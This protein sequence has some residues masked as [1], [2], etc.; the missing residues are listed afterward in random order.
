[1]S[2]RQYIP[3]LCAGGTVVIPK[4]SIEFE[5]AIMNAKVS[6]LICTPSALAALD[7]DNAT[8]SV[9]YVQVAGEAPRLS[10]LLEWNNCIDKLFVGLGP[11]ELC[12][13]ALC[14]E[15]DGKTLCIGFPANNVKAYVVD[16]KSALQ[17]PINVPGELWIA[18]K[19]VCK[20][21]LNREELTSSKF[22]LDPFV[23]KGAERL[24]R[25]GDLAKV[26]SNM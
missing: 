11:T 6:K 23:S 24:Y 21:Y 17:C 12:A 16:D 19:N 1:M 25:T 26:S 9:R 13:H 10:T 7:I 3:T 20:G 15:F 2:L 14:G 4:S 18:G 5:S 22:C 8:K